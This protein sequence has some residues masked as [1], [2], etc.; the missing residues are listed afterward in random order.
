V[1]TPDGRTAPPLAPVTARGRGDAA[2]PQGHAPAP[3]LRALLITGGSGVVGRRLLRAL[4]QDDA[5]PIRCLTRNPARA[6][7]PAGV[8]AVPGG[9][10]DPGALAR[11]LDGI[12]TVVHLAALTGRASARDH[13][14]VN[15]EGTNR[16]LEACARAGVAR[17]LLVSTIA[18]KFTDVPRYFYARSKRAAESAVR[19]SGLRHLIVRPTIVAADDAPA[20][21]RLMG[22]GCAPIVLT[23]GD[24]RTRVQ[25]IDADD[26][27]RALTL[28][29][30]EEPF[31]GRTIE[32]GGPEAISL[33]ELLSRV[34]RRH[35]G[36]DPRI[37]HLPYAPLAFVLGI[38]E[39]ALP[40]PPPVTVGQLS[41][42][43]RDGTAERSL[44]WEHLR[45]SMKS[46]DE[47]IARGGGDG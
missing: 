21:R 38:V 31:D 6:A 13:A 8:T 44:F 18:A 33:A 42:F 47:M 24:G 28:L 43:V 15:L 29:I 17:F 45:P 41:S 25:P 34:H 14:R 40:A 20:W 3:G 32:L 16:L 9:L 37:L 39:R 46:V 11:A 10:H 1:R 35:R 30:D 22:L 23:I 12:D 36:R 7:L 4:A 27:A 5:R 19:A 2:T 26:L